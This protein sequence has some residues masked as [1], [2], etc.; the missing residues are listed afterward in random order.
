M[1][2]LSS[3]RKGTGFEREVV[4]QARNVGLTARRSWGSD[5]RSHGLPSEV[6]VVINGLNFQC[7]RRK[8]LPAY[9]LPSHTVSGQIIRGDAG[10][11]H[12]VLRLSHLFSL[13]S[14]IL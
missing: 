6:D 11:A 1:P 9:L 2:G 3:K 4:K 8:N 5:G 12:V 14:R 13:I 7:K 10:V